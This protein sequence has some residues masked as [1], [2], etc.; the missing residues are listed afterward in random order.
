MLLPKKQNLEP[1]PDDI[2][3][4]VPFYYIPIVRD[5]YL[6]RFRMVMEY[7]GSGISGITLD[8]G[9]GSGI[10]FPELKQRCQTVIGTDLTVDHPRINRILRLEK[11]DVPVFRSNALRVPL[12]SHSVDRVVSISLLEHVPGVL[13]A[14]QEIH[15]V[16]KKD[17]VA[18]LGVPVQRALLIFF[19]LLARVDYKK[20]HV[21]D[22]L[23]VLD[24]ARKTFSKVE[25]SYFTLGFLPKS[26]S[27][28]IVMKC[29]K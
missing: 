7:L 5:F 10:F 4:P 29:T 16:L 2:E 1:F 11:L 18:V 15:R 20:Y 28:Y 3:D 14:V 23:E 27:L 24:A 22:Y 21:T 19:F 9:C 12:Q 26:Q 17:G 6:K 13:G 25:C 8:L